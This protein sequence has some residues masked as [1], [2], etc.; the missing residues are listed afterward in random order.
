M[1]AEAPNECYEGWPKRWEGGYDPALV[2]RS[3]N[4]AVGW[5]RF[6]LPLWNTAVFDELGVVCRTTA[7]NSLFSWAMYRSPCLRITSV[8]GKKEKKKRKIGRVKKAAWPR[9]LSGK[10]IL[11]DPNHNS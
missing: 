8:P 10:E 2:L 3:G 7:S 9:L 6:F 5:F 11:F 1:G 4:H